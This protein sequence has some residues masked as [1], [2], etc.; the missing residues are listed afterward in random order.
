MG[1]VS[2]LRDAGKRI[3]LWMQ[4]KGVPFTGLP[5][6]APMTN[7][8]NP[9]RLAGVGIEA[10]ISGLFGTFADRRE[11]QAITR[12]DHHDEVLGYVDR[13]HASRP[14]HV[15]DANWYD[16]RSDGGDGSVWIDYLA[17]TGDGWNS[18]FA[19]ASLL[20][21]PELI[22]ANPFDG[23][24]PLSLPRGKLLVMGG[25]Q[26]YPT[27]SPE[28]YDRRLV[29]PFRAALGEDRQ[30]EEDTGSFGE[31]FAVPGNHDWYDGLRSFLGTFCRQ[32]DGVDRPGK[33]IGERRTR[34]SRSYFAIKLPYNWWLWGLDSQLR[35]YIDQPQVDYF[36]HVA[37]I[38]HKQAEAEGPFKLI[39]C[40]GYPSWTH[41]DPKDPNPRFGSFS[42]M[43]RL[44]NNYGNAG[45]AGQAAGGKVCLSISG[46]THHYAR[47]TEVGPGS[48]CRHYVTC[49]GGGAYSHPTGQV[50]REEFEWHWP[51]PG[52]KEGYKPKGRRE[53]E[54]ATIR[55]QGKESEALY[56]SKSQSSKTAMGVLLIAFRNAWFTLAM[57][58]LSL[59]I[60]RTVPWTPGPFRDIVPEL[61]GNSLESLPMPALF[62]AMT[63]ALGYTADRKKI[64]E[65]FAIG[66]VN[67]LVQLS[68]ILLAGAAALAWLQ[69]CPEWLQL[70]LAALAGGFASATALGLYFLLCYHLF[71][72]MHWNELYLGLRST[73]YKSMLRMR[74]DSEGGLTLY[75]IGLDDSEKGGMFN[76]FFGNPGVREPLKPRLIEP[77]V[78]IC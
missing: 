8:L 30:H 75:A 31:L 18:T 12:P 5:Q 46:D 78:T 54:L 45:G 4:A 69:Q 43:E 70:A 10:L 37:K 72:G 28:E 58:A 9:F 1:L 24:D 74:V 6:H 77:P 11:A 16:Y 52:E 66:A 47:H 39:I 35:G 20:H 38:M 15:S 71:G 33:I 50:K 40:T 32:Y 21:E 53:F 57:S 36:S 64:G 2:T 56:P 19:M 26:V 22:V 29:K 51:L 44:I 14:G 73:R 48:D 61:F 17:D 62:A 49:G 65:R 13:S 42:Y 7:W 41:V 60:F 27:A 76:R 67:A 59:A 25:D 23:G 63:A 34:Q 68:V 55:H 3:H